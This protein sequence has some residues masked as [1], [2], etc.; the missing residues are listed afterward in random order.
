MANIQA[1]QINSGLEF[2]ANEY[3]ISQVFNEFSGYCGNLFVL[4]R[5]VIKFL[6][7]VITT[8]AK[9]MITNSSSSSS[10]WTL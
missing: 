5:D 6:M 8:E 4:D 7:R 3:L 2:L 9:L 1:I 10:G